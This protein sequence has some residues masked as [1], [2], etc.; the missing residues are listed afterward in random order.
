[1]RSL[2]GPCK[3]FPRTLLDLRELQLRRTRLLCVGFWGTKD[4]AARLLRIADGP[5]EVHRNQIGRLELRR[6]RL[7]RA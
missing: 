4:G 5:D 7:A 2:L 3:I 6:Q 1:M